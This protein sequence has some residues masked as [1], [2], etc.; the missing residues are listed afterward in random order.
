MLRERIATGDAARAAGAESDARRTLVP[1]EM[2]NRWWM[3]G[4]GE[5][6]CRAVLSWTGIPRTIRQAED[7]DG[8]LAERGFQPGG[9]PPRSGLQYNYRGDCGPAAVSWCGTLVQPDFESAASAWMSVTGMGRGWWFGRMTGKSVIRERLEGTSGR[10]GR[11]SS[12]LPRPGSRSTKW[13]A[14]SGSPPGDSG[15][16]LAALIEDWE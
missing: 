12:I 5:P 9:D 14:A 8:R 2:V 4:S 11:C 15:L 3:S 1:D 16:G 10:P 13:T 6:D 7:L